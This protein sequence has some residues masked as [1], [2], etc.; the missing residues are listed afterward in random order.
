MIARTVMLEAGPPPPD[1]GWGWMVVLAGFICHL[2]MDGF[3]YSSGIFF[4]EFLE[5]FHEGHGATSLISS[6]T[7]GCYL[8]SSPIASGLTIRYGCRPIAITGSLM[9]A[10]GLFI[11]IYATGIKFLYFSLGFVS[12]TG[13]GLTLL[14]A[15]VCVTSYFDRR[16]S[17]ATGITVCGSGVGTFVMAPL[18][19]ALIRYYG[20]KGALIICS[21]LSLQGRIRVRPDLF[22]ERTLSEE[23]RQSS[24]AFS[25]GA[26]HQSQLVT[27]VDNRNIVV[28]TLFSYKMAAV[29]GEMLNVRLL[30]EPAFQ[31]FA[32][33]RALCGMGYSV[34]YLF[35]PSRAVAD[36][37]VSETDASFLMSVIGF[38]NVVGRIAI[39]EAADLVGRRRIW[40]YIGCVMICGLSTVLSV[41]ARTYFVLQLYAAAYGAA[42]GGFITL[43]SVVVVDLVGL[44]RL[45]NAFGLSLLFLGIAALVGP[46]L[47][48]WVLDATHSFSPGFVLAGVCQYAAGV[49]LIAVPYLQLKK[50]RRRSV[51][52]TRDSADA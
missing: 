13:F 19:Q 12:G 10:L 4:D 41:L 18:M 6:I 27:L 34:P 5:Y 31:A 49:V 17:L 38:S 40:I 9:S 35:L 45:T 32:L 3:V 26:D 14:P 16:R 8:M 22:Y 11:S 15:I 29:L 36:L 42:G 50:A 23:D 47:S 2:V 48:G 21:G 52:T 37:G 28:R 20:W 43:S 51:A 7:F 46:P 1:G 30:A 33:S 44:D 39:G 25:S 24:M